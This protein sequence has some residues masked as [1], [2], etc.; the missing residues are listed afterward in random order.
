[1]VQ[2]I[3]I[4]SFLIEV[5][6]DRTIYASTGSN[7]DR[8]LWWMPETLSLVNWSGDVDGMDQNWSALNLP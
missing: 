5:G 1:M 7:G 6:V 8:W 3:Y 2:S 4:S